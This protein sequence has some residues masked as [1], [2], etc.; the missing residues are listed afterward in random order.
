M[1][2]IHFPCPRRFGMVYVNP[3][4]GLA[5]IGGCLEIEKHKQLDDGR[6]LVVMKGVERFRIR[7]IVAEKPVMIAEVEILQDE[8]SV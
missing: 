2:D 4:G 7:K 5:A 8:V 1:I 6:L 3:R